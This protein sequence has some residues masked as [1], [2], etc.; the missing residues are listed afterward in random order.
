MKSHPMADDVLPY[1]WRYFTDLIY[2]LHTGNIDDLIK[3]YDLSIDLNQ[4]QIESFIQKALVYDKKE[5]LL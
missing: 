3:L 2:V 5:M 4:H 1:D